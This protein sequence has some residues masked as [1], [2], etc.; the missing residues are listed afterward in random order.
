LTL[1]DV[2]LIEF[3]FRM[4]GL[5]EPFKTQSMKLFRPIE[6]LDGGFESLKRIIDKINSLQVSKIGQGTL[7]Y[8]GSSGD[9]WWCS[10]WLP[11]SR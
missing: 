2:D 8:S 9:T 7:I 4:S 11:F 6:G 1:L 10:G 3:V 5:S